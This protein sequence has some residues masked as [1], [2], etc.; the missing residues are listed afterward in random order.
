MPVDCIGYVEEIKRATA[1]FHSAVISL[2][3]EQLVRTS[4]DLSI[5]DFEIRVF[6]DKTAQYAVF[7]SRGD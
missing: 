5:S 6:P 2:F 1:S 3:G 4:R 7:R